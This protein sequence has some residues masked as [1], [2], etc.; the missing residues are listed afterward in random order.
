M[1][2]LLY[3]AYIIIRRAI[4][5]LAIS[6]PFLLVIGGLIIGEKKIQVSLSAYYHN[7]LGD[8]FVLILGM[9]AILLIL[10]RG[11]KKLFRILSS[12]G[13][14]LALAVIAFPTDVPNPPVNPYGI[15]L[16]PELPT[17]II[18]N[19]SAIVFFIIL[20][21]ISFFNFT[22]HLENTPVE[23]KK[24]DPWYRFFGLLL[25][26][27]ALALI[28]FVVF[29]PDYPVIIAEFLGLEAFGWT[30]LIKSW[31]KSE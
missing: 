2:K 19:V 4:G 18:H 5:I 15:F 13:G 30:W 16:L 23:R 21:I 9:A 29:F 22:D 17:E 14:V 31:K 6:L 24:K 1:N 11:R 28:V 10:Y 3:D 8:V 26:G 12:I 20:G 7:N 27:A 25:F